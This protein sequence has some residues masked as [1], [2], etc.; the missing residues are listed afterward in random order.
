MIKQT[1]DKP[2]QFRDRQGSLQRGNAKLFK[3]PPAV[4]M[5]LGALLH[6]VTFPLSKMPA[7]L[8]I[9]MEV[10]GS[11]CEMTHFSDSDLSSSPMYNSLFQSASDN[12]QHVSFSTD[13][14]ENCFIT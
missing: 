9:L 13:I 14:I 3:V 10:E 7:P 11:T 4:L 1:S 2:E 12:G 8:P 6:H 5:A